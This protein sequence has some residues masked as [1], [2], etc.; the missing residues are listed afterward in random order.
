MP[1]TLNTL[2]WP[3]IYGDK[4]CAIR[5]VTIRNEVASEIWGGCVGVTSRPQVLF[6]DKA[7]CQRQCDRLNRNLV[8]KAG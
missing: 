7:E 5:Y 6:H 1:C 2:W 4:F 8:R 3:V